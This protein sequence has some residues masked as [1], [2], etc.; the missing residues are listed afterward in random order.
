MRTHARGNRFD[1]SRRSFLSGT[2]AAALF[3]LAKPVLAWA[4]PASTPSLACVKALTF[5]M[6]GTVFDFYDPLI[7]IS[8][9]IGSRRGL[10]NDW[11]ATLPGDWSGAAHDIIVDISAGRR[12]WVPNTQVYRE[13][14]GPLLAR[15]GVAGHLAEEDRAELL[16]EWG[17][18][19]PWP[20][21]VPGITRLRRKYTM[22]TLTNAAMSQMTALVKAN[23]LPFD[24]ILTGELCRAF[25]PDP[26]VYQLAVDY[27][28]FRP[29]EFLMVSAH[30]W[31]L[32][33]SK[34]A[35]FRTA[36]IPRP[37]ELGPGHAADRKPEDFIDIM[38]EDLVDL[39]RKLDVLADR[40][41]G[42]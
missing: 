10:P 33:A 30:K 21:A 31:D 12:P 39:A 23:G 2:A 22:C 18:M 5:D 32:Q 41:T 17:K 24:E 11:A 8:Q 16:A 14:L 38:A 20:D 36:Y 15:R 29:E 6:Q 13:A 3:V 37:R 19:V 35:G 4:G 9:A 25:K 26:R 1:P 34:R 7:A 42:A 28:G 40:R 27:A